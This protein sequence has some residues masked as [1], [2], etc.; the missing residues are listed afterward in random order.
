MDLYGDGDDWS[1]IMIY[2]G[3]AKINL[4]GLAVSFLDFC[5]VFFIIQSNA[6][7]M[8]IGSFSLN[9]YKYFR[10]GCLITFA[11]IFPQS[12]SIAMPGSAK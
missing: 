6:L 5:F 1:M 9:F 7:A 12:T 10:I 2:D 8:N 4:Y 3:Q 11:F